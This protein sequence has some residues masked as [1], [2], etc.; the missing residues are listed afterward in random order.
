MG[1]Q[2]QTIVIS[3]VNLYKG[4]PFTILLEVL[5]ALETNFS[6]KY[7]I[8]SLVHKKSLFPEYQ[9]IQLL[10]F[11]KSRSSWLMHIYYE[12]YYFK[13][14]YSYLN[15]FLWLSLHDI[16]PNVK[17]KRRAVYCHN[18]S[19][20]YKASFKDAYCEPSFYLF[21][22]FYLKLYR[23]NILKND[24]VIVQQEWLRKEFHNH[25]KIKLSKIIIAHPEIKLN[26][27]PFDKRKENNHTGTYTFFYPALPRVFKNFEIILKASLLL[28]KRGITNFQ[29]LL[30]IDGSENK[31]SKKI[32]KK[33]QY[34]S[35]IKLIGLQHKNEMDQLY[36]NTDC[37]L[38]PS[39]LETWGLPISEAKLY[40]KPMI[41]ADLPYAKETAG[42]YEKVCFFNPNDE[43]EL[44][45]KM[46]DL[47]LQRYIFSSTNYTPPAGLVAESWIE[48]FNYLLN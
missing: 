46:E 16:T 28:Q 47:I 40:K 4:G 11:P 34:I 24:F 30:T 29:I 12:Y 27:I 3:A 5:N 43:V 42:Q 31:F 39:K 41:I 44:A 13:K 25:L 6:D 22:K 10:E 9:N 33:C 1:S 18:A 17:A 2:K 48:M 32:A 23:K 36:Q 7:Q 15:P 45:N 8:I 21:N 14:A 20:F 26:T 37:L 19:P 38:F 35:L